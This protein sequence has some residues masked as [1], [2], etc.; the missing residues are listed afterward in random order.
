MEHKHGCTGGK[1][2]AACRRGVATGAHNYRTILRGSVC[3]GGS[4]WLLDGEDTAT[5][6]RLT[7]RVGRDAADGILEWQ[8]GPQWIPQIT[9][10]LPEL[11]SGRPAK[12]PFGSVR[13]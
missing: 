5:I 3:I 9:R 6:R 12:L 10:H 4:P 2:L 8:R 1:A 7:L 13:R 11:M